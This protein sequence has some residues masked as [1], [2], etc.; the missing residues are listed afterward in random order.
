MEL[1]DQNYVKDQDILIKLDSNH[2]IKALLAEGVSPREAM[3]ALLAALKAV[4]DRRGE[5]WRGVLFSLGLKA[6]AKDLK[7]DDYDG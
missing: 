4:C 6:Y 7:G 1:V 2:E 3:T 5:D